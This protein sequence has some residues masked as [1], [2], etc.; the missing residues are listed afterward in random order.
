MVRSEETAVFVGKDTSFMSIETAMRDISNAYLRSWLGT[1]SYL[2]SIEY[3]IRVQWPKA[4][5]MQFNT[6]KQ[7]KLP[8][9]FKA[10][11]KLSL[12]WQAT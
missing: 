5:D 7:L 12:G 3:S 8:L 10:Y 6:L 11:S 2:N 4:I 9:E 1:K